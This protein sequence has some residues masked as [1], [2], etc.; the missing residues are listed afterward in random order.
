M[1]DR[2]G[3]HLKTWKGSVTVK[4]FIDTSIYPADLFVFGT[5][6]PSPSKKP[7]IGTHYTED[8]VLV[9]SLYPDN[10]LV[11]LVPVPLQLLGATSVT[12]STE[13]GLAEFTDLY[14]TRTV[15]NLQINFSAVFTTKQ[16]SMRIVLS[17]STR[18][19]DVLIPPPAPLVLPTRFMLPLAAT[20]ILLAIPLA[21]I[22][23]GVLQI[24][25]WIKARHTRSHDLKMLD[26]P[27][28]KPGESLVSGGADSAAYV[29]TKHPVYDPE[30]VPP[31]HTRDPSKGP[32]PAL[33]RFNNQ[34]VHSRD[35][36]EE[37]TK[38]APWRYVSGLASLTVGLLGFKKEEEKKGPVSKY[39]SKHPLPETITERLQYLDPPPTPLS[40]GSGLQ[41]LPIYQEVAWEKIA[42]SLPARIP[43]PLTTS[44]RS[45]FNPPPQASSK[46]VFIAESYEKQVLGHPELDSLALARLAQEKLEREAAEKSAEILALE[47]AEPKGWFSRRE[48]KR[49]SGRMDTSDPLQQTSSMSS[50]SQPLS[51]ERDG[52]AAV[53][54]VVPTSSNNNNSLLTATPS[55]RT[56]TAVVAGSFK[57]PKPTSSLA[58]SI[59]AAF[60]KHKPLLVTLPPFHR[61]LNASDDPP[62]LEADQVINSLENWAHKARARAVGEFKSSTVRSK[63]RS[64]TVGG[65][66]ESGSGKG[67]SAQE[68]EK[69]A[70]LLNV[71]SQR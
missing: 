12:V 11:Q 50:R 31:P 48:N 45:N 62:P 56:A 43:A 57:A 42:G 37:V 67:P 34:V 25:L 24:R 9:Q 14:I 38:F 52:S 44:K 5:P 70:S 6:S 26:A 46:D 30:A 13:T 17:A 53:N 33:P 39:G 66:A 8:S 41:P 32:H 61:N 65:A 55:H 35:P 10:V 64:K 18:P 69:L 2:H 49:R 3:R 51:T 68:E 23:Y 54:S 59:M 20:V 15:K 36:V 19:F 22:I 4:A 63:T 7:V 16:L 60:M 40:P 28:E 29:P 58:S 1:V 27:P 71:P 47:E 21:C